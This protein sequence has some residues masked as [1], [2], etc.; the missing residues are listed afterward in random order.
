MGIVWGDNSSIQSPSFDRTSFG[1][2]RVDRDSFSVC[3]L[4]V[5]SPWGISRSRAELIPGAPD[6][7]AEFASL[8]SNVKPRFK[9]QAA[10]QTARTDPPG[11]G[12]P[13]TH[14]PSPKKGWLPKKGYLDN[15]D[16]A[17]AREA[18]NAQNRPHA[19][20]RSAKL[21]GPPAT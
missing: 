4:T 10:A 15:P 5:R 13:H 16:E 12:P 7:A 6:F 21:S 9:L 11:E 17:R 8:L 2:D 3:L 1:C 20:K 14:T 19:P 18:Q